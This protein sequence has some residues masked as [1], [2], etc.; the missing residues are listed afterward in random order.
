MRAKSLPVFAFLFFAAA[1][2][3]AK[4]DTVRMIDFAFVPASITIAPGDTVVWKSTQQ[5]CITH[6]TTRST[7]PMTW[8]A[9]VPLNST[10]QQAF[11]QQGTF[12]Y[13]CTPH[14]GLGMSGSVTVFSVALSKAPSLG[15][16][17][18]ALLLA[19]LGAAGIWTLRKK[20]TARP[21]IPL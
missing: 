14:Q 6:T 18:L 4:T 13:V 1:G 9:T 7:G 3:W 16:L 10:F 5:C 11:T 8:D 20:K 12:N 19:S 15:W 2:V 21:K 17:G